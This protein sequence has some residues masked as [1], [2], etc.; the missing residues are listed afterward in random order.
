MASNQPKINHPQG[1]VDPTYLLNTESKA[2]FD[3]ICALMEKMGTLSP[4]YAEMI[5]ATASAIGRM[6]LA[7]DD[8]NERGHISFAERGEVKNQ[9]FTV[10]ATSQNL[11]QKGLIALGLAPTS[12]GKIAAIE[13]KEENPFE[14]FGR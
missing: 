2:A 4:L 3:R 9:S 13:Q 7:D 12:V 8:L 6:I 10:Y 5:T 14:K 1:K 11:A